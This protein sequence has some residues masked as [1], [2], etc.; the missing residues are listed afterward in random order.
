[1]VIA[2]RPRGEN[3]NL[4]QKVSQ[5]TTGSA[6]SSV[7]FCKERND[8]GRIGKQEMLPRTVK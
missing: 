3:G 4:M 7:L 5:K 6:S 2:A 1:M 8:L